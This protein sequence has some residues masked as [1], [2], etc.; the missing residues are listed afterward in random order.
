[1]KQIVIGVCLAL[2]SLSLV[3]FIFPLQKPIIWAN[4][5]RNECL[6]YEVP[7]EVAAAK[8]SARPADL[9]GTF[10]AV[11]KMEESFVIRACCI[12]WAVSQRKP[13]AVMTFSYQSG[14][15][16]TF[17]F[18]FSLSLPPSIAHSQSDGGIIVPRGFSTLTYLSPGDVPLQSRDE[19]LLPVWGFQYVE[20]L[21]W[22]A[23]FCLCVRELTIW[24]SFIRLQL[25]PAWLGAEID[26]I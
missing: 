7:E 10:S 22:L 3:L 26:S 17:P 25:F 1:M 6:F 18:S 13:R 9:A 8:G 4:I 16:L 5:A 21:C 14:A 19:A 2:N 23:A 15:P 24:K 20:A 12:P 11:F